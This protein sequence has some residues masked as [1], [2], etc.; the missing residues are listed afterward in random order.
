MQS[1]LSLLLVDKCHFFCF[2]SYI[3]I[4]W[5]WWGEYLWNKIWVNLLG[6]NGIKSGS[7]AKAFDGFCLKKHLLFDME[8]SLSFY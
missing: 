6:R 8:L 3:K 5:P 2:F 1:K 4:W 7:P